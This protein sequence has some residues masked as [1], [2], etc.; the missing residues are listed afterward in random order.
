VVREKGLRRGDAGREHPSPERLIDFVERDFVEREVAGA[1]ARETQQ[2]EQHLAFCPE[3]SAYVD[4]LKATFA[5][6][7]ADKVPEQ[8]DGYWRSF[9]ADVRRRARIQAPEKQRAL[10]RAVG[11]ALG[12]RWRIALVL[13]PGL[14]VAL[15]F[16]LSLVLTGPQAP[17]Y[18]AGDAA[19][20][21]PG[22]LASDLASD[23]EPPLD[24]MTVD[25][26]A[27]SMSEDAIFT[28]MVIEAADED[29]SSIEQYLLETEDI[30]VLIDG[31]ADDEAQGLASSIAEQMKQRD[32][33]LMS[34]DDRQ[35][36][37]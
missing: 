24:D 36:V 27:R 30:G 1:E 34:E 6:A 19:S 8:P 13:S 31:L 37:S 14:A 9:E 15:A 21:V 28:D 35:R 25:E 3:C 22:S 33:R 12:H 23:L 16:V 29:I 2:I 7:G 18:V 4:S 17:R 32:T 10:G 20:D 11:R 26:I 5:L